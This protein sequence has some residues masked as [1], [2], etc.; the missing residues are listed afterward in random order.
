MSTKMR[1]Q[2]RKK[3]SKEHCITT[4]HSV[5]S[6]PGDRIVQGPSSTVWPSMH[7]VLDFT[8]QQSTEN[9]KKVALYF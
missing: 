5:P 4:L 2:E 3:T 1:E 9:N 7:E 6:L 8:S